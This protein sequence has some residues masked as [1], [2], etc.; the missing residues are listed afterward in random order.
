MGFEMRLFAL[1]MLT[2]TGMAQTGIAIHGSVRSRLET[3][4][5]FDGGLGDGSYAL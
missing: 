4:D 5:W 2:A 3:W 1:F